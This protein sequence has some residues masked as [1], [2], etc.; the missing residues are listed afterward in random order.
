M[1]KHKINYFFYLCI[2]SVFLFLF[3]CFSTIK[4]EINDSE[5]RLFPP[6]KLLLKGQQAYDYG[7]Y[8]IALKYYFTI[9]EKY[10]EETYYCAWAYYEIA[11]IFYSQKKYEEAIKYLNIVIEK[12]PDE[13][14][15][16]FM[17]KFLL[18][19][20]KEIESKNN[21]KS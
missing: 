18:S 15:P 14:E 4:Y 5:G 13:K 7:N 17:A 11:F 12:Y 8:D 6:E 20:I 16:I 2:I 21:K 1:S 10:P 9:I 3:S 19:K